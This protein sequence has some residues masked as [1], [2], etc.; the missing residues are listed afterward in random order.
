MTRETSLKVENTT[1][2]NHC[3]IGLFGAYHATNFGDDLMAVIF[4][5]TLEKLGVAFSV[6]GLGKE[7]EVRYGFSLVSSVDELVEASDA[8]V[9]GGGGLLQPRKGTS[10]FAR[11]LD[12][13]LKACRDRSI[14]IFC[15]SIGGA[16]LPLDKIRPAS[17]R[18]LV[19]QAEF[20]T[21]RL[22]AEIPL[23]DQ[24]GTPGTHH[25]DIVWTTPSFFPSI[26][27]QESE[28]GRL[29]IGVSVYRFGR[30]EWMFHRTFFHILAWVRRDCDFVFFE[31]RFATSGRH[32]CGAL[33]P[34][35]AFMPRSC[36]F[37]KFDSLEDGVRFLQTLDLV[38]TN[39]LHVGV[40]AMSYAR[41]HV[42]LLPKRKTAVYLRE[43]GLDG[44]CWTPRRL[45]KI[46]YLL[47]PRLSR[48][49]LRSFE[50]FDRE[51]V[52]RDAA[53]HLRDLERT[54]HMLSKPDSPSPSSNPKTR[55]ENR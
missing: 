1:A 27:I 47:V 29:A 26:P 32:A 50:R 30:L 20:F 55:S 21:V 15:F 9:F 36:R 44:F 37:Y 54:I 22:R 39:Q 38:I 48:R 23:L 11:E 35:W 7:Y 51:S 3:R 28:S 24:V 13:L 17:R 5:R 31:A 49:L 8:I 2:S 46:V 40:A 6:Y 42:G 43:L 18:Q 45:W 16:G 52:Q 4:G 12:A 19:E 53:L 25:E 14:P 34:R 41:P 10:N 33:R